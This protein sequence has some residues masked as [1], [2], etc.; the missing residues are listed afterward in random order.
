M[1]ELSGVRSPFVRTGTAACLAV[2]SFAVQAQH[3]VEEWVSLFNGKDLD[4]WVVKIRG[5]EPGVNFG[6]TF[7]VEDGL[8]TTG[9]EAY[10]DDYGDRF[11]HIF[12]RE[13]YSHYRLRVEYRFVGE[14]AAGAPGWAARNSGAMVHS[15]DPYSMPAGQDFPI[16]LEVQFL[17]GLGDGKERPTA[18]MCSP[19]T[20]IEYHGEFTETHCI[21]STSPTFHGDEWVTV[22]ALVLG[23]ERI[24]HH[25][26]GESV[27]EYGNLTF[28]GWRRIGPRSRD[29]AGRPADFVRLH[30]AAER[31]PSDPVS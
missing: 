14:Q 10:G 28:G 26:N 4:D 23:S 20:H 25:V 1:P 30:R 18:N 15:Q 5:H 8:M 12:Y 31:K 27:M 6:N 3:D 22:E 7:R 11:G 19:G 17:G 16:S 29:E 21:N 2:M 9:Y 13:P 24:V